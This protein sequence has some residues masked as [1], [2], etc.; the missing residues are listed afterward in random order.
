[1][2]KEIPATKQSLS[3]RKLIFGV[4]VNDAPYQVNPT[5]NGKRVE[6]K[7]Y[8]AWHNMVRRCYSNVS[9]IKRPTYLGCT[10]CSGWLI[11]SSFR[12]WMIKQDWKGKE[13]DKDIKITGNKVYSPD[14][15]IFVSP[16]INSL[17][18]DR[19]LDRGEYPVGVSFDKDSNRFKSYCSVDGKVKNLGRFETS[20]EASTVYKEF[21]S[22]LIYSIAIEQEQPLKGY[23]IR[24]SGE[25]LA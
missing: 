8:M 24:I 4:G 23:L 1:M 11:F 12:K 18:T 25:R 21:K 5:I 10:V 6:C 13:I 14:T 16:Q 7:V 3:Q 22:K 9:L 15:C 19:S 17:L 2:F 20:S